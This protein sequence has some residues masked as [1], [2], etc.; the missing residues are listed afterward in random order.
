MGYLSE[1]ALTNT[2]IVTRARPPFDTSFTNGVLSTQFLV[3]MLAKTGKPLNE[4][5]ETPGD[6]LRNFLAGDTLPIIREFFARPGGRFLAAL[7]EL[8]DAELLALLK[9]NVSRL[10]RRRGGE[11]EE[12]LPALSRGELDG[13]QAR[14]PQACARHEGTDGDPAGCQS[15]LESRLR[16]GHA[17]QRPPLP[18]PMRHR[19]L[20]AGGL[21]CG[22]VRLRHHQ[23]DGGG[24]L[25]G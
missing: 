11:L 7:Y 12:A 23:G 2:I 10:D 5:L 8:E 6:W 17:D 21:F 16:L 14:R 20:Q 1:P 25:A 13:A 9:A 24:Q 18:D 22:R 19:R 4:H 15:A 3:R